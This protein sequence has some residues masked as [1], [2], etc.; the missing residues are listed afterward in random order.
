LGSL[1]LFYIQ[2]FQLRPGRFAN[3]TQS[4]LLTAASSRT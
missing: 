4:I 1:M 3:G 2:E